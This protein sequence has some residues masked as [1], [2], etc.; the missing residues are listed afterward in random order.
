MSEWLAGKVGDAAERMRWKD[1]EN[2]V[3]SF[4]RFIGR[5]FSELTEA[6][7][8]VPFPV[9]EREGDGGVIFPL[10]NGETTP[11]ECS[12]L[13]VKSMVDAAS[14]EAGEAIDKCV[15]GVP[16]RFGDTQREATTGAA[17]MSGLEKVKLI[18]EPVAAAL[19]Y[20][21][22][23]DEDQAVLVVDLGGGTFD[24]SVLEVGGG[25][26]EVLASSGDER[27]GGDDMDAALAQMMVHGNSAE[28]IAAFKRVARQARE[29]LCEREE[30]GVVPHEKRLVSRDDLHW[31]D[32]GSII[33]LDKENAKRRIKQCLQRMERPMEEVA[34][35]S[36]MRMGVLEEVGGERIWG[37]EREI[38][39]VLLV[40]GATR[41]DAVQEYVADI[42]GQ[43]AWLAELEP[44]AAIVVGAAIRAA[45]LEGYEGGDAYE[46]LQAALMRALAGAEI[47]SGALPLSHDSLDEE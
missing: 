42:A 36:G 26:V 30:V 14:I 37:E 15:I 13:L 5:R 2:A 34:L 44:E 40:G 28:P 3:H 12:A 27:L 43:S 6:E 7:L 29:A 1:P 45:T 11:E 16:A 20:G 47:R 10:P 18:R 19:A 33:R 35:A 32:E 24:V 21:I 46:P 38:D 23:V 8:S 17:R 9:A 39:R 22:D 4:K 31:L 25:S 41:E